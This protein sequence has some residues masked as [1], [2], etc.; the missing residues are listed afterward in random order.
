[1]KIPNSVYKHNLSNITF[2]SPTE[3]FTKEIY[4]EISESDFS[5]KNP[6]VPFTTVCY[7]ILNRE[8]DFVSHSIV[9]TVL[10]QKKNLR[11]KISL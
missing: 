6:K 7:E 11:H 3:Y 1:M 9:F 4:D 10:A 8:G 5:Y 2:P